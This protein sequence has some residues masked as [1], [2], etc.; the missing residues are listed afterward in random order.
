MTQAQWEAL[1]AVAGGQ[2]LDKPLC[3]FIVDSPWLPGWSGDASILD[4]YAS[5]TA[6]L[7]V[8]LKACR[9]FPSAVFLP[10]FWPEF[11]MCTEPSAFGNRGG[12]S[13][14]P[15]RGRA[16]AAEYRVVPDGGDGV[17]D[18]DAA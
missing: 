3:G 16:R 13:R 11:G 4:Y 15:L 5:E 6:W 10:G 1:V 8:N 2:R 12:G 17:P 14:C 7:N 18:G 9:A